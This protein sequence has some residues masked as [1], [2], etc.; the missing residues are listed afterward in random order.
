MGLT[1]TLKMFETTVSA[2]P[3][4]LNPMYEQVREFHQAGGKL[5]FGT[6]VGYMTDYSTEGE[7]TAL[8]KSGLGWQDVLAMLTTNP[9]ARFHVAAEKGTIEPGKLADL[10]VLSA[11]PAQQLTNFSQVKMT[12][13]S[14]RILWQR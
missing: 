10:T 7:F 14:G 13:R 8:G 2:D 5:L 9:A 1:P 6:D 11:D 12:I 3:A 4:Y